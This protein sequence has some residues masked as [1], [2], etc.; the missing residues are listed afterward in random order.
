MADTELT[1][2]QA[3][4]EGQKLARPSKTIDDAVTDGKQTDPSAYESWGRTALQVGLPM[5]A[6]AATAP[7]TGGMSLPMIYATEGLAS[8]GA[9]S[10][11]QAT[12]VS[13]RS[14]GQM[15][16]A[17][18]APG[19]GRSVGTTL[20]QI[21]RMIPGFGQAAR[22]ALTPYSKEVPDR[23]LPGPSAQ[24]LYRQVAQG[25]VKAVLP[26]FPNL[27]GAVKDLGDDI[28]KVPWD[29]LQQDLRGT[30]L[31]TLF[32]QITQSLKG[33]PATVVKRQPTISGKPQSLPTGL[34]QTAVPVKAKP[35]GLTF[36]EAQAAVEG[37]GKVISR[38]SDDA[39]RGNYKK[40]YKG[41]LSD[42][43]QAKAPSDVPVK[44]WNEARSAY[45]LEKAR[46]LLS[47]QIQRSTATKEGVDI[48]NPDS[49]VK[50]LRTNSEF[51]ERVSPQQYT[52]VMNEFRNMSKLEGHNMSRFMGLLAGGAVSGNVGG[53]LAGYIAAEQVSKWLMTDSGR[54]IIHSMIKNPN[55][56]N[57][58]R[59]MAGS[60]AG[61]AGAFDERPRPFSEFNEHLQQAP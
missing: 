37:F 4:A 47:E 52:A 26:D 56:S 13:D 14:P 19:V 17:L 7:F 43:E 12:G 6:V 29:K 42:L 61:M 45:K 51:K 3:I 41:I 8:L 54:K 34:P 10:L 5:A 31:E 28:G 53:A 23:L 21:P 22:A 1:I 30:G 24:Q 15:G 60:G 18:A 9:E 35:P 36:E 38:T 57:F 46:F 49:M 50:W 55:A 11:L 40:L 20:A 25:N 39:M 48:F 44:V 58:R 27:A 2:D 32:S 59:F 16:L 33:T